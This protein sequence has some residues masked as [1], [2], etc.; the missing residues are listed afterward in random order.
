MDSVKVTSAQ[1]VEAGLPFFVSS[2]MAEAVWRSAVS[3]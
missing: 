3:D 1:Q 2:K